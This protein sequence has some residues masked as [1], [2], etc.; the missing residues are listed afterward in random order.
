MRD[1]ASTLPAPIVPDLLTEPETA[2]YL[3]VSART[4]FTLA[5]DGRLPCLRIGQRKLFRRATVE[6][7]LADLE[8]ASSSAVESP[9]G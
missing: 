2:E 9:A 6:K 3:R 4:V 1:A 5:K 8:A 7:F